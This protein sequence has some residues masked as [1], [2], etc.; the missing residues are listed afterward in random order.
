VAVAA[1]GRSRQGFGKWGRLLQ[2]GKAAKSGRGGAAA[3][4]RPDLR[5]QGHTRSERRRHLLGVV[6]ATIATL[7]EATTLE[8]AAPPILRTLRAH[9]E[10]DKVELWLRG[11]DGAFA[12][13]TSSGPD[14]HAQPGSSTLV[15]R[16]LRELRPVWESANLGGTGCAAPL[17]SGEE[18][19]GVLTARDNSPR[20]PDPD[21]L[22][23]VTLLAGLIGQF[24]GRTR[25]AAALRSERRLLAT[26]LEHLDEGVQVLA[27]DGR[28]LCTSRRMSEL[29]SSGPHPGA[30]A[31]STFGDVAS[32]ALAAQGDGRPYSDELELVGPD[33]TRHLRIRTASHRDESDTYLVI[34]A[35]DVS[36]ETKLA[37]AERHQQRL[38][39]IGHYTS[40][41][42]SELADLVDDISRRAEAVASGP[43]RNALEQT[44]ALE[45]LTAINQAAHHARRVTNT[46]SLAHSGAPVVLAVDDDATMRQLLIETLEN[47]GFFVLNAANARQA[48]EL[49]QRHHGLIDLVI[50]DDI[51]PGASGSKLITNLADAEPQARALL[52]S[53]HNDPELIR[54]DPRGRP[55]PFLVKPFTPQVLTEAAH[56]LLTQS[57]T[58][59]PPVLTG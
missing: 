54:L 23:A 43:A 48:R 44:G 7:A 59:S 45:H 29:F 1:N 32:A 10:W 53:G 14:Q 5:Q 39:A 57:L 37:A 9:L 11:S 36:A 6:S 47:Q 20:T 56:Q 4:G 28:P 18:P 49:A 3:S 19:L 12:C 38:T 17:L 42:N 15:Q 40:G 27:G 31:R 22:H 55:I 13:V 50:A 2:V 26:L 41:A 51:M 35:H 46:V 52:I 24:L 8:Q 30:E 16:T 25:A 58:C 33:F 34:V 21:A